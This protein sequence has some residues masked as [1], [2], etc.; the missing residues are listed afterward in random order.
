MTSVFFSQTSPAELILKPPLGEYG[1]D[2]VTIAVIY[3]KHFNEE[4]PV[5]IFLPGY[6]GN[7]EWYFDFIGIEKIVE[8]ASS[9][10]PFISVIIDPSSGP[11]ACFYINS[12]VS[13]NWEDFICNFLPG[14]ISQWAQENLGARTGK[15][16]L[17]GHSLGG[18]GALR[19]GARHPEVF[20]FV[21]SVSGIVT[22]EVL[23]EWLKYVEK[24][25]VWSER[26]N[27]GVQHFFTRL[28]YQM[29]ANFTGIK[30]PDLFE[31]H[32]GAL[33]LDEQLMHRMRSC[34]FDIL[35]S[36]RNGSLVFSNEKIYV[37]SGTGDIVCDVGF[38][39]EL[40]R[41]LKSKLTAS[42]LKCET[43]A[44][45]HISILGE[46]IENCLTFFFQG[47]D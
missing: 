7:P 10:N 8:N 31:Y 39:E 14:T 15:F 30:E 4:L 27:W 16:C 46:E 25:G 24:E 1:I 13:G 32:C 47:E 9:E 40:C 26:E 22:V 18:F 3:P 37:S 44:G 38:H 45:D 17:I 29:C 41:I 23:P 2:S 43:P 42:S 34:D 33:S 21:G 12:G 5:V 6:D 36:A 19:I 20:P 28:S 11:L 35:A